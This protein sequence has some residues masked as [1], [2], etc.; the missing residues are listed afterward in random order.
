MGRKRRRTMRAEGRPGKKDGI[1]R[2][3]MRIAGREGVR[4]IKTWP[5]KAQVEAAFPP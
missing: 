4:T 1:G 5:S 3:G 2:K